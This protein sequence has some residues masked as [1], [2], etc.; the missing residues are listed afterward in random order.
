MRSKG[1]EVTRGSLAMQHSSGTYAYVVLILSG[2][3]PL[4]GSLFAPN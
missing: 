2:R 3:L 1:M 4:V